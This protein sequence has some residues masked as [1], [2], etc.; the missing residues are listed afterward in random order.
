MIEKGRGNGDWVQ[1]GNYRPHVGG[2]AFEEPLGVGVTE[3]GVVEGTQEGNGGGGPR[4]RRVGQ[5]A[6]LE[7]PP[8]VEC[9]PRLLPLALQQRQRVVEP[10]LI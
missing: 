1:G 3:V 9:L 4:V 6:G 7:A 10:E 2:A 8:A 5:L